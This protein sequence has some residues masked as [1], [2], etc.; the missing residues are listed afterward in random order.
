MIKQISWS[1]N[2]QVLKLV[3]GNIIEDDFQVC[4]A[5]SK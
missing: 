5:G 1:D 4:E 2:F 3:P